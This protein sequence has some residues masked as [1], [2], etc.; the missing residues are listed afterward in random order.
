M[1]AWLK[2]QVTEFTAWTGFAICICSFFAPA[3]VIFTLGVLLIAIDDVKAAE[4]VK[5]IAPAAT[6]KLDRM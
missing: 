4:F 2:Q 5:K 1:K 6:R 3:W